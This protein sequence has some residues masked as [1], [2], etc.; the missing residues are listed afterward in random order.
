VN[1]K[2]GHPLN[3]LGPSWPVETN[4]Y[5]AEKIDCAQYRTAVILDPI[6]VVSDAMRGTE[7][8]ETEPTADFRLSDPC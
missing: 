5:L 3:N 6:P 4:A 7:P 2:A 1:Q 8:W